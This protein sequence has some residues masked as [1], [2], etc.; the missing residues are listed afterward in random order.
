[1]P[2]YLWFECFGNDAEK[3]GGTDVEGMFDFGCLKGVSREKVYVVPEDGLLL[4][5]VVF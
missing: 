4:W 5:F 2:D 1:L 3:I